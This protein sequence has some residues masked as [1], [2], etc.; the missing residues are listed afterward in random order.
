MPSTLDYEFVSNYLKEK[1]YELLSTEYKNTKTL[2]DM[3]CGKCYKIYQ[4]TYQNFIKG[5]YHPFCANS[6]RI[7]FG[8][9]K[10][11]V[12]LKNIICKVCNIEFKPR[13]SIVTICS[14]KCAQEYSRRDEYKE[15]AQRNGSAGGK[16]SATVQSRR[17]KNE[18]Y[19]AEKCEE[20]FGKEN[21]TTNEACFDGFDCDVIIHKEKLAIAWNGQW[22]YKQISKTQSLEQVQARDRVK[23]AIITNKYGYRLYVIK[24]TGKYDRNF[25]DQEFEIMLMCLMDV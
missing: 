6:E 21:V 22:H 2:L 20:Y 8:G 11:P 25:V 13:Q 4:Q 18:V 16:I 1:G 10:K 15:I 23:S 24:D 12:T 5:Y 9:Y 17:S 7:P 3:K 14:R 19:F